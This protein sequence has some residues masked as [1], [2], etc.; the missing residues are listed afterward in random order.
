MDTADLKID[1]FANSLNEMECHL[2]I[3]VI[4]AEFRFK[5]TLIAF[6]Y[7]AWFSH[8]KAFIV[9]PRIHIFVPYNHVPL[10]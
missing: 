7:V 6:L 10:S 3:V 1:Y 4:A 5:P 2:L 8:L 9:H